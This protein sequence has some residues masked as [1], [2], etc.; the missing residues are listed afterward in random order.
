MFSVDDE[1]AERVVA[2]VQCRATEP[3]EREALRAE[4]AGLFRRQHGIDV[5]VVLVPPHSLPQTSSGKLS[6]TRAKQMLLAGA[7][8]DGAPVTS[9]A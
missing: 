3:D 1:S 6:R 9:A 5:S 8:E 7:F 2:L 4:V